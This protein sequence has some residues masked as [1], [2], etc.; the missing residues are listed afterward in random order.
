MLFGQAAQMTNSSLIF[1]ASMFAAGAH[2]A[3]KQVRKYTGEP[4][5]VHPREVAEIVAGVGGTDIMIAAAHLH[6][7][8]EDTGVT[9]QMLE[10]YFGLDVVSYVN[11]LTDKF[12]PER[13]PGLNRAARKRAEAI[14][15]RCVSDEVKTIKLADG[16]CNTRSIT[17]Y[18]PKFMETYGPEKR[19]LLEQLRGGNE[20][21]W[22]ILNRQLTEAGY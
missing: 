5:V 15:Y 1:A 9:F 4:Y 2:G 10:N 8:L 11:Q 22:N 6:D 19:F 12:T 18:D 13:F 21:L 3:V 14:R 20:G 17:R 16:I 7:V